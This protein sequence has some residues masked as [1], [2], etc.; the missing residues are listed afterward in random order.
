MVFRNITCRFIT[1]DRNAGDV[2]M[3]YNATLNKV[4]SKS[5]KIL[6]GY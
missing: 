6:A 1:F 4:Q 3:A 2:V 5:V